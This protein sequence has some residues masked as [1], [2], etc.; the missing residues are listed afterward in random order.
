MSLEKQ[1]FINIL[2]NRGSIL[3]D[4]KGGNFFF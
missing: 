2:S 1:L 4:Y 3:A